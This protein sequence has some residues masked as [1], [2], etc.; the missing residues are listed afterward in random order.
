MIARGA[1]I[2][3]G[4]VILKHLAATSK[5]SPVRGKGCFALQ[6]VAV[7]WVILQLPFSLFRVCRR[8]FNICERRGLLD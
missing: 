6:M 8:A 2:V 4:C 1:V 7:A 3:T 5:Q